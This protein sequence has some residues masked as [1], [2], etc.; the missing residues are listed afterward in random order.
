MDG[1]GQSNKRK[2]EKLK[3]RKTGGNRVSGMDAINLNLI[4]EIP[5]I[6]SLRHGLKDW[7]IS[8]SQMTPDTLG[9][10]AVSSWVFLDM[11][12]VKCR[13]QVARSVIALS[14]TNI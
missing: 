12:G 11:R 7:D 6:P 10:V 1:R 4:P 14:R 5:L 2:K 3:K 9:P 13:S 8:G